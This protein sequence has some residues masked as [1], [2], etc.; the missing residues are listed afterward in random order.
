[1]SIHRPA[2]QQENHRV[3]LTQWQHDQVIEADMKLQDRPNVTLI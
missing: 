3:K 1:M 2:R